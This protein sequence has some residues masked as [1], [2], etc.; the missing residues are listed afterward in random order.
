[1]GWRITSR[2]CRD[3]TAN[4]AVE[5]VLVYF[6]FR[7]TLYIISS[8]NSALTQIYPITAGLNN[9]QYRVV[10]SN[11]H[12]EEVSNP[13]TLTV[14]PPY[15]IQEVVNFV[16]PPRETVVL[17]YALRFQHAGSMEFNLYVSSQLNGLSGTRFVVPR[18]MYDGTNFYLYG[19]SRPLQP[20]ENNDIVGFIESNIPISVGGYASVVIINSSSSPLTIN[21]QIISHPR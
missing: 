13:A 15:D 5:Y 18:R 10:V 11:E 4:R 9:N 6:V 20:G 12:G 2:K 16:V 21:G 8:S 7:S 19:P 17:P 1:M 3:C 14:R